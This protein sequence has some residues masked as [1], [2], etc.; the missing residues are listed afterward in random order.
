MCPLQPLS[1][2]QLSLFNAAIK[3]HQAGGLDGAERTY[4][5]ILIAEP[6]HAGTLHLLGVIRQ[7]QGRHSEA[8]ELIGRAIA[9]NPAKAVYHN[10][11][12]AALLSLER[13]AEAESSFRRALAIRADYADALANLG[14]AQAAVDVDAAAEVSLRRALQCQAWHC[15]ATTRLATLLQRQGRMDEAARLLQAALA[16]APCPQFHLAL[17]SLWMTAG[18]PQQAAEC[19]RAA[20]DLRPDDAAAHFNLGQALQE[21]NDAAGA[22]EHFARA[23]ELRPD[24]PW[25]RLRAEVCGPAVFEKHRGD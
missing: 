24:K 14:M 11:Y 15:D 19:C 6:N 13:Y 20:I 8:L 3:L 22:Q 17:G 16:A 9:T 10:N 12:G 7:Q 2:F 21:L 25:W 18:Q 23:A 5:Q 4:N 1:P